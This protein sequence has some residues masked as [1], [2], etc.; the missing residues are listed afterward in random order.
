LAS[1]PVLDATQPIKPVKTEE[2]IN[3]SLPPWR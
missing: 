2:Y 1:S 3:D